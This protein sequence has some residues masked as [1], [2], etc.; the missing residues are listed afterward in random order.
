MAFDARELQ[1]GIN[2]VANRAQE[3][4]PHEPSTFAHL[5]LSSTF[6][7]PLPSSSVAASNW[8]GKPGPC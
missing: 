1:K 3:P 7:H 8:K 5:L 4:E 2:L 6:L